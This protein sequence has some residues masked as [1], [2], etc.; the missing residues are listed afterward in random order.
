MQLE[1][2]AVKVSRCVG[3]KVTNQTQAVQSCCRN[4]GLWLD[5]MLN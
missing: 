2:R 4:T 5:E 1:K 3:Y